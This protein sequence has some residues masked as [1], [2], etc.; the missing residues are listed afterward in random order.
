MDVDR[1]N[2]KDFPDSSLQQHWRCMFQCK[3]PRE[4]STSFLEVGT[5]NQIFFFLL[6]STWDSQ[7]CSRGHRKLQNRSI[8][9]CCFTALTEVGRSRTWAPAGPRDQLFLTEGK[10][11]KKKKLNY[12]CNRKETCFT[13]LSKAVSTSHKTWILIISVS[14]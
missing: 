14:Q 12:G 5:R 8:C 10:K 11:G 2:I 13:L 4:K 9:P 7:S 6:S 3:K 1:E